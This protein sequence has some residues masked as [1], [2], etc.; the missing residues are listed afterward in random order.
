REEID[1]LARILD[2]RDPASAISVLEASHGGG[3]AAPELAEVLAA[4]DDW[5]RRTSGVFSVRPAGA[6][7]PRN[8]DALG[9]AYIIDRAAA[10]ARQAWP[11]ID[12]LMLNIGG[13]IVVWGRRPCEIGIAD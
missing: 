2:T 12:A 6:D 10:A 9:K 1:R 8:V 11:S 4:Y 5:E 7:R 3:E 13:D